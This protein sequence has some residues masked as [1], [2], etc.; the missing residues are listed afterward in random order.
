MYGKRVAALAHERVT[1]LTELFEYVAGDGVVTREE[2]QMVHAAA[3]DA[4]TTTRAADCADALARGIGRATSAR[5]IRDL[6]MAWQ[7]AA[8]DLPPTG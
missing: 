3:H 6:T 4:V 7:T 5:H 2:R 8:D 1:Y